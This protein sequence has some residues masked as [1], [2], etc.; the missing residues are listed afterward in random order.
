MITIITIALVLAF[1]PAAVL[2]VS[3]CAQEWGLPD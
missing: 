3:I 2:G 1:I